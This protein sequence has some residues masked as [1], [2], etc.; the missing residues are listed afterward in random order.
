[1]SSCE[2][3]MNEAP[4]SGTV[5]VLYPSYIH[6]QTHPDQL[7]TKACFFGLEAP[8]VASCRVLELGCGDGANLIALAT[9]LP[10]SEFTGIDLS[11]EA[12]ANGHET[13]D[14]LGLN[15]IRLQAGNIMAVSPEFGQFD[16]IIAHGLYS[17]VPEEVRNKIL[18]ICRDNLRPNGVAYISYGVYPGG[19]FSQMLREMMQ[20]HAGQIQEP[21]AKAR[22]AIAFMKFLA[23]S[24]NRSEDPYHQFL[25]QELNGVVQRG[26]RFICHAEL[27]P[28]HVPVYFHEFCH[29]A[30]EH[31]LQFLAESDYVQLPLYF[32]PPETTI[33]LNQVANGR[34]R[35]EQYFDFLTGR[36]FRQSLLCHSRVKLNASISPELVR[37]CSI[38]CAI[39]PELPE[40]DITANTVAR[41]LGAKGAVIT[42]ETPLTKSAL[43]IL[44]ETWPE[45][46]S[47]P[48]LLDQAR[49][50]LGVSNPVSPT[51]P[52]NADEL[53]LCSFLLKFYL[54][55]LVELRLH[56][57][58]FSKRASERPL[59]NPLAQRQLRRGLDIV[60]NVC[61]GSVE[62]KDPIGRHLFLLLDGKRT[63]TDLQN[64]MAAYFDVQGSQ[65][66]AESLAENIEKALAMFGCLA[67]LKE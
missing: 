16:Y 51:E 9:G 67:L 3:I 27:G 8:P 29:A 43:C 23:A 14:D 61:L 31:G 20:F 21:M 19:H 17:W 4:S 24:A 40:P 44:G 1:M 39:K 63:R 58:F 64:E 13:A 11:T 18:S 37:R 45:A 26:E 46:V 55:G 49:I 47:F 52:P 2:N 35:V 15:N 42:C 60:T 7:A 62:L 10:G 28:L 32:F 12:I 57:P 6:P 56:P 53:Q 25:K 33:T 66:R 48:Q 50:R 54:P 36:K 34:I 59:A 22:E 65:P 41:F 30:Q 5:E 38:A